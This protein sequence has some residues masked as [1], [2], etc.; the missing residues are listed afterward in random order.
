M[1]RTGKSTLASRLIYTHPAETVLIYDW[2]GGEFARRLG[3][4]LATSREQLATDIQE[5]KRIICYDAE[6]GE[7]DVKGEGF[8]WFCGMAFELAGNL[9]GRKLFVCDEMQDLIDPYNITE[10]LDNLLTR[11]GRRMMDTCFIGSA[12]NALHNR[13]RNQVS[14]LYHFRV[15]DESAL[16]YSKSLGMEP[17]SIR[18]LPDCQFIYRD[19]RTGETKKLDLWGREEDLED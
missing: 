3:A 14:E 16:A 15:I 6:T 18:N 11:S 2:Q 4:T 12:A 7:A 19:N 5:G 10:N 13:A 8:D 17:E 1:S 9:P